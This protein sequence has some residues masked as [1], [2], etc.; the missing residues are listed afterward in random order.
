MKTVARAFLAFVAAATAPAVIVLAPYGWLLIGEPGS[1]DPND[2]V[3]FYRVATLIAVTA[4]GYVVIL[5]IPA[6]LLLRWRKAIH[7]WSTTAA[8]FVVV[9]LLAAFDGWPAGGG[10]SESHWDGGKM[11]W[12]VVSGVPTLEGWV[13]YI[14]EVVAFG[15]FGAIGGFAFWLVWHLM[16]SHNVS[17]RSEDPRA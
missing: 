1:S 17:T 11:V 6:F 2:W 4:V 16:R 3:R 12:T 15:V 8:G 7:W 10:V 5:G 9:F 13:R 14:E